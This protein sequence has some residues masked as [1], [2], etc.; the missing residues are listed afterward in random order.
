MYDYSTRYVRALKCVDLSATEVYGPCCF[1]LAASDDL[2]VW[3]PVHDRKENKQL[4]H[5]I[6]MSTHLKHVS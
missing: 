1:L 4:T 6:C 2:T 3:T 5:V